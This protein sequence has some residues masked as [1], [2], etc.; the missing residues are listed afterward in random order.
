MVT[1]GHLFCSH[2]STKR[3]I[4]IS[5]GIDDSRGDHSE[6][7]TLPDRRLESGRVFTQVIAGSR[8]RFF[9]RNALLHRKLR[10]PLPEPVEKSHERR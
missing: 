8:L 2:Q 5:Y 1:F 9:G 10:P 7:V 6:K 4:A 3:L